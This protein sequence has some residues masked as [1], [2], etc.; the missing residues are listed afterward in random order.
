MNSVKKTSIVLGIAFLLEV[1]TNVVN[2]MILRPALITTPC[3]HRDTVESIR[4]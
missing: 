4:L 1:I 3:I 2:G